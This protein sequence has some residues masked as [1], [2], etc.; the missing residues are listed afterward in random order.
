MSSPGAAD[1]P[2]RVA[3]ALYSALG[4][5]LEPALGLLLEHRARR[6]KEDRHRRGERFGRSGRPRPPGRLVWVHAASV[7]ETNSVLPLVG[8]LTS[9]GHAVLLTTGT[10]T[11]AEIAARRLPQGAFHQYV[12]LDTPGSVGRFLDHWRPD[13]ALFVESE[14]WPQAVAGLARRDVPLAI[15]NG[16]L[17]PR[18][19]RSWNRFPSVAR[20]VFGR[21]GMCTAQ[22]EADAERF[23]QLGIENVVTVGNLKFDVP[24]LPADPAVLAELKAAV[25]ARPVLVAASTHAGEEELVVDAHRMAAAVAP[26]CL[27]IIAPRHPE[28]GPAIAGDVE[29][30]GLSSR[31]RSGGRA[32]EPGTAVYVAD[33]IGEMGLWFRLARVAFLGG[34]MVPHGGQNPIE[35]AQLGVPILHGPHVGNFA[36]IYGALGRAGGA[37]EVA[38]AGALAGAV[39]AFMAEPERARAAGA[40]AEACVARFAGSLER[41][42]RAL[43]PLLA[44]L[45]PVR[46]AGA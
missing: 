12:P 28:R 16:R 46:A 7:G 18:S 20:A 21:A 35:P 34:S 15:V 8:R 5:V 38:D 24:M 29:K 26:D 13:L 3:I 43:E 11:S 27:T 41:T 2:G 44:R 45:D 37:F 6:G 23:R 4:R 17:S 40:A 14:I 31:L 33:T 32:P 25:G 19:F 9:S 10:V 42:I 22:S 36:E 39:R 1:E 30:A